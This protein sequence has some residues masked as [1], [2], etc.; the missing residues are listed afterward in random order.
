MAEKKIIKRYERFIEFFVIILLCGLIWFVCESNISFFGRQYCIKQMLDN[1]LNGFNRYVWNAFFSELSFTFITISLLSIMINSKKVIYWVNIVEE[2]LVTPLFKNYY[3]YSIYA[4]TILVYTFAAA[5]C[6]KESL[7]WVYFSFSLLIM[8]RLSFKVIDVFHNDVAK[9]RDLQKKYINLIKSKSDK[10]SKEKYK[11]IHDELYRKTMIGIRDWNYDYVESNFE[12]YKENI[13]Y[14]PHNN[15]AIARLVDFVSDKTMDDVFEILSNYLTVPDEEL[16]DLGLINPKSDFEEM[17]DYE[18]NL[19]YDGVTAFAHLIW[20]SNLHKMFMQC[21]DKYNLSKNIIWLLEK[22]I[23]REYNYFVVR[24]HSENI[25]PEYKFQAPNNLENIMKE[26][27]KD[28]KQA[29]D[30]GA[31]IYWNL[32]GACNYLIQMLMKSV[33]LVDYDKY[34]EL[35]TNSC[36]SIMPIFEWALEENGISDIESEEIIKYVKKKGI[37]EE[38]ENFLRTVIF[39]NDDPYDVIKTINDIKEA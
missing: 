12:F 39:K 8:I 3:A 34:F 20:P 24:N 35:L 29:E 10:E 1:K 23:I 26:G 31:S 17:F 16:N 30:D 27:I 28:L 37:S 5:L 18:E 25:I 6:K 4:F 19:E 22:V 21:S 2:K 32:N 9:K 38:K 11:K 7:V 13:K 33:Y 36:I 14:M 15:D